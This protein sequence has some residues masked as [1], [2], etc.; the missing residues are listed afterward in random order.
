M[1]MP[2]R[3]RVTLVFREVSRA[4]LRRGRKEAMSIGSAVEEGT[5][6]VAHRVVTETTTSANVNYTVCYLNS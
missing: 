6:E 2:P 3:K 1:W 5:A 4:E